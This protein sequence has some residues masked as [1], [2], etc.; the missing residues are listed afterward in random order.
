M[1]HSVYLESSIVY[2]TIKRQHTTGAKK[3]S[4][5]ETLHPPPPCRV[6][7]PNLTGNGVLARGIKGDIQ[8]F[9]V[10]QLKKED[11][12]IVCLSRKCKYL[13]SILSTYI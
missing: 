12:Q 2:L 9:P 10:H 8:S 3:G 1:I 5:Y 7:P 4:N 11:Q 13:F 6:G